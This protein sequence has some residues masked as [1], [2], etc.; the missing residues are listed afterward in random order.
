MYK[1]LSQSR[2]IVC[3]L[4]ILV[5]H[6]YGTCIHTLI[7][8]HGDF[9]IRAILLLDNNKDNHLESKSS[10]GA[11]PEGLSSTPDLTLR[12]EKTD[13]YTLRFG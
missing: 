6:V 12:R 7:K 11:K 4:L 1:S 9:F 13:C 2:L 10:D 3:E 8:C 5:I